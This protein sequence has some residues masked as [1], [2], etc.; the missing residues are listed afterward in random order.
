MFKTFRNKLLFWFFMFILITIA[1]ILQSERYYQE[2]EKIE[3]FTHQIDHTF[4]F[5]LQDYKEVSDF[6]SYD[7]TN[8]DFYRTGSS[9]NLV[10]HLL[11][12]DSVKKELKKLEESEELDRFKL[13]S[14]LEEIKKD[15]T[16][17]EKNF[18]EIIRLIK[19]R[20]Y[21]D[22][23]IVGEMRNAVHKLEEVEQIE[24]AKILS[25]R[26]REKDYIIRNEAVYIKKLLYEARALK[27]EVQKNPALTSAQ[28]QEIIKLIDNYTCS[29][30]KMVELNKKIGTRNHKGLKN[31][32]D[33]LQ[34]NM[35]ASFVDL[36][37]LSEEK[38]QEIKKELQIIYFIT[39]CILVI[40]SILVSFVISRFITAPL[41]Q[42][43]D[44]INTFVKSN[45]SNTNQE[46]PIKNPNDEVGK[47]TK[48]FQILKR[49]LINHVS[50][51]K[52]QKEKADKANNSKSVFL[53][54]MSHEIRTP[55]NGVL[56][57]ADILKTTNL[58]DAQKEYVEIITI[59]ANNLLTIINDIL[60]FSKI[61]AGGLELEFTDFVLH[62]EIYH[63]MR[64][65][66][67]KADKK[68]L[69]LVYR[70]EKNVPKYVK[71]DPVRVRQIIINLVNNAIKFTD[72]GQVRLEISSLSQ[73]DEKTI[74]FFK[75]IDTGIGISEDQ[76]K[77]LF[78][79]FSQADATITRT[80]GGTGL[81]LAISRDLVRLM[82][83]QIGVNSTLN[84]GSTFWFEIELGLGSKV[85]K[86][87]VPKSNI[88]CQQNLKILL[89]E[90]NK[91]NQKV[92]DIML[93]KF[94][95]TIEIVEN[96]KLAV[97]KFKENKYD[98]IF[99]DIQMPVKDGLS[100]TQE[101][102][103]LEQ[104][105]NSKITII[106]MTAN[107]LEEERKEYLHSGFDEIITKPFSENQLKEILETVYTPALLNDEN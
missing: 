70:I 60:D 54:N 8:A 43:A 75:V 92:A 18:N 107:A 82:N 52:R 19:K 42:L 94:G 93:Q 31:R 11:L 71:G 28:K 47:L 26:R 6:Y 29:F 7:M 50:Y 51:L 37:Y 76:Q 17:Y 97:E 20:G 35:H 63:I 22:F 87:E 39:L 27:T 56:G 10:N 49:E 3:L 16:L 88:K 9:Q 30:K 72:V 45:F 100:A 38:K 13:K 14:K 48:N 58:S 84:E 1:V 59:S 90:D 36:S 80:H 73:S 101:I 86:V 24:L 74:L 98:I 78:K 89:A 41:S 77:K 64:M 81:G 53:A 62:E 95:H 106:A 99:M 105:R 5:L 69:S 61:E 96:G 4:N 83:G 85:E 102:R 15:I 57:M 104:N 25:L 32:T 67:P 79:P 55:M 21:K 34:E 68:N 91:I 103:E 33:K 65:L 40:L 12:L 46:L 66:E 44:Y 23:G 2:K